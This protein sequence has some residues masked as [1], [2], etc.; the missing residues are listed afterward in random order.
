MQGIIFALFSG[1]FIALQGIFNARLGDAVGP[2]LSVTIVHFVGLIG[3]L[4]IYGFVR[5]RKIGGFRTLPLIYAS[6]GLLGVLVVVTELTS[7]QLLGMT[8]AM[9][10]LLVAQILCAFVIDLN[11]WF[12]VI[13]KSS[14]KGQWMGVGLMLAGVLIFSLA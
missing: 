10:L 9:S 3:C 8:W 11:G 13:K 5:D 7:I 14:N 4:L 2:W 12:G 1:L 6:G